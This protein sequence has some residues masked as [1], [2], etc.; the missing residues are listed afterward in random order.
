MKLT[1][2]LNVA[3]CHRTTT[4]ARHASQSAKLQPMKR[5]LRLRKWENIRFRPVASLQRVSKLR[6][7]LLVDGIEG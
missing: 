4:K 7:V 5:R 2:T 1:K 3:R 6:R